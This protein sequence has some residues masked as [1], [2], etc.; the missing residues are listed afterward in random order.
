MKSIRK[1]P[2]FTQR[3]LEEEQVESAPI[4]HRGRLSKRQRPRA[5]RKIMSEH[6]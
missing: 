3:D 4:R 2:T 1:N 6:L 5:R